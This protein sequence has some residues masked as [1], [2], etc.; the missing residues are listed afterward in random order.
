[1]K[2][3]LDEILPEIIKEECRKRRRHRIEIRRLSAAKDTVTVKGSSTD[4]KRKNK[5]SKSGTEKRLRT[6]SDFLYPSP[7]AFPSIAEVIKSR[8]VYGAMSVTGR[9]RDME[10]A[11][12]VMTS[13]MNQSVHFFAVYD[14]HGG[15]HVISSP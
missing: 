6:S 15:A 7:P 8:P 1:M 11:I 4:N 14:G 13:M 2:T 5:Q 12:F 10:D 9:A 3:N